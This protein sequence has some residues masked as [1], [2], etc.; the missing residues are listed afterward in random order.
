MNQPPE[1]TA[2][3][4]CSY[5]P[6]LSSPHL[7]PHLLIQPLPA[8]FSL[9]PSVPSLLPFGPP[10]PA[11]NPAVAPLPF[12]HAPPPAVLCGC[13]G[14]RSHSWEGDGTRS[15]SPGHS[16]LCCGGTCMHSVSASSHLLY[17]FITKCIR[18]ASSVSPCAAFP[19]DTEDISQTFRLNFLIWKLKA[20]QVCK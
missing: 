6:S 13:Q 18:S 12:S 3:C 4:S 2:C 10:S 20:S 9:P 17:R 14:G 19:G 1:G 11:P 8:S 16:R 7:Q 15:P 5:G